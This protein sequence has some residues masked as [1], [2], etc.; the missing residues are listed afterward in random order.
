M[1]ETFTDLKHVFHA[2]GSCEKN[3]EQGSTWRLQH[4]RVRY[5]HYVF[6]FLKSL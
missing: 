5:N 1:F 2:D 6:Q 3:S 4:S